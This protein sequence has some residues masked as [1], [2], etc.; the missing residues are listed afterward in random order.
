MT[1][2]A[3][4][5]PQL[6][7]DYLVELGS[8]LLAAGCPTY[9]LE[10]LLVAVAANEGFSADVFAVPTGLFV[11]IR[12]PTGEAP[13]TTMVRVR[14]WQTN[15]TALADLD[16]LL[17]RVVTRE[18]SVEE[19]RAELKAGVVGAPW[20]RW[21]QLLAGAGS[22]AGAAVSFGGGLSHF[23]LAG[24]AG[25][26]VRLL[27]WWTQRNPD[28]RFL[29]NFLG[30]VGAAATGWAA[31]S[32]W[33]H[34]SRDVLVLAA[35]IPLLPGMV[36]TTGLAELTFKNLVAG[37]ARLMDAAMTLLA[38]VFGI[39]VV[40]SLEQWTGGHAP[41]VEVGPQTHV[42]WRVAA[43]A[44]AAT[45]FGVSLGMP[46]RLL[47]VALASAGIV[48]AAQLAVAGLSSWV[49]AGVSALALGLSANAFARA[50]LRPTQLFLVPGLLLLVPGAFGLKSVE[51]L[52]RGDYTQGAGHAVDMVTV[53]GALVMGLLVANVVLPP[54][55]I[56]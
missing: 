46:R 9:R 37:T 24:V 38:L 32:F 48:F 54:K 13:V 31:T 6:V 53:A 47:G 18:L 16:R 33:P 5:S 45:S 56:L 36:L 41:P 10:E 1:S 20:P 23:V 43:V 17:N 27:L 3:S 52:L 35:V 15:L 11:S 55:K 51:A 42:L 25:L 2:P 29:G 50:T 21:A 14:E 4:R 44:V 7:L 49:G 22:C 28:L 40:V 26:L 30:G 39:A 8:D 12:T 19:A 34:H